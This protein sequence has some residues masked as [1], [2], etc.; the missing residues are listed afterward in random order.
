MPPAAQTP[1]KSSLGTAPERSLTQRMDALKRAN[2]IRT[3][4][5]RLKRDLKAGRTQ[6][7]GLLLDPPEWLATAKV[8]DLLLAVPKYGRVKASATNSSRSCAANRVLPDD[9]KVLVVTGPSGVGKGTII[10]RL[11]ERHPELALSISAT[12]RDP[13]EGEEHGRDYY[14]LTRDQFGGRVDKGEF[15]EH[16]EYAGNRYGTP[17]SELDRMVKALV[18]E[19]EIQG[20]LQVH[21]TL[22]EALQV[23]IL[24]PSFE[25]LRERLVGRGTDRPEVIEELDEA[26][27]EAAHFGNRIVNA[28]L[29][30]AVR[31]LEGLLAR[32]WGR[33]FEGDA[34]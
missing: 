23:F 15:L 7:H 25:T 18:L 19:I 3:Q 1:S 22:P 20:A 9:P 26:E 10:K 24:P 12:T 17:R 33:D 8:F 30:A 4:R 14:F 34:E 32:V 31:E 5:A 11:R 2:E 6:I 16:A 29:D 13:R 27:R 28:D 21:E